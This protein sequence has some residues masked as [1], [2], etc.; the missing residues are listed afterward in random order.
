MESKLKAIKAR[1]EYVLCLE[2]ANAAMRKYFVE[3]LQELINV[4]PLRLIS[5]A[6]AAAAEILTHLCSCR[7]MFKISFKKILMTEVIAIITISRKRTM[8]GECS[9]ILITS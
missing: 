4:S 8:K 2:A 5:S 6:A 9:N 1:N 3:D 7:E